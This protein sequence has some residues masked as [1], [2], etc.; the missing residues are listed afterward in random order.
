[1]DGLLQTDVLDHVLVTDNSNSLTMKTE[2]T[3]K[4]GRRRPTSAVYLE[5]KR[6]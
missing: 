2:K 1:M 5:N 3:E 6:N 4:L